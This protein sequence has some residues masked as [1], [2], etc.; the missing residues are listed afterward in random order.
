MDVRLDLRGLDFRSSGLRGYAGQLRQSVLLKADL[1]HLNLQQLDFFHAI[2]YGADL[3]FAD[4]SSA[5]LAGSDMRF[6]NAVGAI[7]CDADLRD[8]KLCGADLTGATLLG[9]NLDGA[10]ISGAELSGAKL[11]DGA[12]KHAIG[13][14]N[15]SVANI[16]WQRRPQVVSTTTPKNVL[17]FHR[18]GNLSG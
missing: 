18:T 12:L 1:R 10:D 4:F 13:S 7:L 3:R 17:R 9:A 11:Y 15:A 14:D 5:C 6:T 16:D 2:L 8:A